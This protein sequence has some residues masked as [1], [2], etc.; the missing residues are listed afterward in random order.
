M[1]DPEHVG[2]GEHEEA[3]GRGHAAPPRALGLHLLPAGPRSTPT[4]MRTIW[5]SACYPPMRCF[6]SCPATW[7]IPRGE[8]EARCQR[9]H[10]HCSYWPLLRWGSWAQRPWPARGML[11]RWR[12]ISTP[13]NVSTAQCIR[14]SLASDA[15]WVRR[16]N[17]SEQEGALTKFPPPRAP[18][19]A[20]TSPQCGIP[21]TQL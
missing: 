18:P 6:S 12:G 8:S 21:P 19:S 16:G 5:L 2:E 15:T 11:C 1:K 3:S 7:G 14:S 20:G 17:G 4:K 9:D 13:H 10:S